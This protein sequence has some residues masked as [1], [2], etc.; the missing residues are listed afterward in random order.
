MYSCL[1]PKKIACE[2]YKCT[3]VFD[4]QNNDNEDNK[5]SSEEIKE[6]NSIFE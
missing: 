1:A 5:L 4:E 2:N 6:A 3:A